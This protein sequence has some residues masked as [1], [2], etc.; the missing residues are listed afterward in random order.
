MYAF[1]GYY[2]KSC[3]NYYGIVYEDW[4]NLDDDDDEHSIV[5]LQKACD[6]SRT[7]GGGQVFGD[8]LLAQRVKADGRNLQHLRDAVLRLGWRHT[9]AHGHRGHVWFSGPPL[10]QVLRH[11][12]ENTNNTCYQRFHLESVFLQHQWHSDIYLGDH[13]SLFHATIGRTAFQ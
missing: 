2:V 5:S 4:K 9:G 8:A 3:L 12:R 13:L 7:E 10:A 11:W 6:G 1:F